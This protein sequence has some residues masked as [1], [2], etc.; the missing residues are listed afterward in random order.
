MANQEPFSFGN[1][2]RA[3]EQV[4][5]ST[6]HHGER[7]PEREF[8]NTTLE[9]AH[10]RGLIKTPESPA[11]LAP[12]VGLAPT[13]LTTSQESFWRKHPR[14]AATVG[15]IAAVAALGGVVSQIGGE[16]HEPGSKVGAS[17]EPGTHE[18]TLSQAEIDA[19]RRTDRPSFPKGA[20]EGVNEREWGDKVNATLVGDFQWYLS[21][22]VHHPDAMDQIPTDDFT[23]TPD[24]EVVRVLKGMAQQMITEN[25][26]AVDILP[27]VCP[28]STQSTDASEFGCS[29][30][31]SFV[32]N[33]ENY[34]DISSLRAE[35]VV[36]DKNSNFS[37]HKELLIKLE[38]PYEVVQ[39]PDGTFKINES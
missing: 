28:T 9:E 13:T 1:G 34:P 25:P 22:L 2:N 33:P 20:L 19:L 30:Y 24:S 23:D 36:Q 3:P 5:P 12:P 17:A 29:G 26:D 37:E 39:S 31:S 18:G 16:S 8:D 38:Q 10:E 27:I 32:S 6:V 11:P 21:T 14:I 15:G 7:P 4:P 35:Y